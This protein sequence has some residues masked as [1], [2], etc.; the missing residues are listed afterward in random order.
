[1]AV[2]LSSL[3][4]NILLAAHA[5]GPSVTGTVKDG[6]SGAPL[7]GAVVSFLDIGRSALTDAEGRYLLHE[8]PAGSQHVEVRRAGYAPRLLLA[9]VPREGT[10]EIDVVLRTEP[11][12]LRAIEVRAALPIPGLEG[13]DSTAFP[14]RALSL[15]AVRHHPLLSEPDVLQAAGG[16][17][18]GLSPESPS[19]IHVRGGTSDQVAYLLDGIPVLSPY[20][21]AGIFGAWNPDAISR[22]DLPTSTAS[23]ASPDAL[24]GVM[25]ATTRAPGP[26]LHTQASVSTT[27]ARFTIDG[28]LGHRGAGYLFS[29]RS[30]SPG[31]LVRGED[32]AYLRGEGGDWLAKVESP[33]FGGR[34]S[35]VGFGSGNELAANAGPAAGQEPGAVVRRHAFTWSSR[36]LGGGWSRG[37]GGGV[38][39]FRAWSAA[40]DA[41]AIWRARDSAP[42]RLAS[43]R[44]DA[45]MV[46]SFE[47]AGER[48]TTAL[49]MRA[50]QRRTSYHLA[51]VSGNGRSVDFR[52]RTPVWA[53]FAG[54]RQGLSRRSE[55]EISLTGSV[56]A[57]TPYF[58]PS[59]RLRWRPTAA[60]SVTGGYARRHQFAQ[61]LR[62]PE[63]VVGNVFP[64]DLY[65]GAGDDGAGVPVA[66][67]NLGTIGLEYRPAAHT[68]IGA[69]GWV[70]DFDGLALVAP[71]DAD[72]FAT[73][74]FLRGSGRAAGIALEA[75][76]AGT[77]YGLVASYSLQQVRLAYGDSSYVPDHGAPHTLR[78]GIMVLPTAH[79]T[80][81]VGLTSVLGRRTTAVPGPFEWE[82]CNLGDRGCEFAGSPSE[83]SEPLGATTLPGYLRIDVGLRQQFPLRLGG[84][85]GM[86]AVFGTV[87]NLLGRKNVLTVVVD[88][89][90]GRRRPIHMLP[91]SPL[92]VGIDWRY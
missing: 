47:L 72:P 67:S 86:L 38:V 10:L 4:A 57:G 17:E 78:A 42:E 44:R 89:S 60:L 75:A 20:H 65:V 74:G 90:T 45:G 66:R 76:A 69:Y 36:S 61:S 32:P 1:M 48:N 70:R 11:V 46:A 7:A 23:P 29:L 14:D 84:R 25:S 83:R 68:R 31:L 15:A 51:P 35:L 62:N 49:G 8:I 6:E 87:S 81:R 52:V 50:E 54:R 40:G 80:I 19:G 33:L 21:S 79:S 82:A 37:L 16:G 30:A 28:P 18:V 59:V 92:V 88:P 77:R 34:L 5:A 39:S 41:G 71:R 85:S 24:S 53:A 55:V 27:Q 22:L 13:G 63:S 2:W 91:R 9:L 58:S 56:V 73:S 3:V 12:I 43:T 26:E 64:V